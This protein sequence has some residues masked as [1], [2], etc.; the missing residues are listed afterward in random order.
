MKTLQDLRK[1]ARQA[2]TDRDIINDCFSA[3]WIEA[4]ERAREACDLAKAEESRLLKTD[5]Y[6]DWRTRADKM[7]QL[8]GVI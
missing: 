4:H 8:L 2:I 7:L 5:R 6:G 1:E 3:E